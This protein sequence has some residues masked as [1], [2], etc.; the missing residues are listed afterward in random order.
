[1]SDISDLL[2]RYRRG[3]ELVAVSITG[4]AGAELD[5]VPDPSKWSIRKIVA[6][7]ADSETVVATRF[8]RVIAEDQPKLEAWDQNLWAERLDYSRRKPSQSLESFRRTR[9]E[10][11]ELLKDLPAEAFDRAG[12]HNER[13]PL[14]LRQLLQLNA[15]H[16]EGHAAQLRSRRAEYKSFKAGAK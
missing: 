8:R 16:A 15:E 10:N 7:L 6:H 5:W 11:Y 14:T 12:I 9:A 13:G 3:A 1:M 4:A 2:E